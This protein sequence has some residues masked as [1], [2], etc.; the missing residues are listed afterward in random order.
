MNDDAFDDDDET[1][2]Y[3]QEGAY[4]EEFV[5]AD[6]LCI[7]LRWLGNCVGTTAGAIHAVGNVVGMHANYQRSRRRFAASVGATIEQITGTSPGE[8]S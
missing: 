8:G 4:A 6:V 5:A 3:A 2:L 1:P 7:G